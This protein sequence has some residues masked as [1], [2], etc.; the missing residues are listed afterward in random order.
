M[1]K[2]ISTAIKK[3]ID[4]TGSNKVV[5]FTNHLKIDGDVY[6][7]G[8]KCDQCHEDILTLTNTLV[9]RLRDYCTCEDDECSCSDYVCFKY[10]WLNINIDEIVA[11][12]IIA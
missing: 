10:D 12:S 4:K 11:Y 8:T 5:I 9:C 3:Q 1:S 2:P 7:E 6:I